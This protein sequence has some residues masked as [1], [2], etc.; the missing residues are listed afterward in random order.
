MN[1]NELAERLRQRKEEISAANDW[2]RNKGLRA[3]RTG[4]NPS[5]RI[6]QSHI[7]I[8]S[9]ACRALAWNKGQK[10][11]LAYSPSQKVIRLFPADD[12]D[13]TSYTLGK[14]GMLCAR[15]ALREFGIKPPMGFDTAGRRLR[16]AVLIGGDLFIEVSDLV[17]T[18][19]TP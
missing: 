11:A 16:D 13:G 15:T 9:S 3:T 12:G 10:V 17:E 1:A 8:N 4:G 6:T 14:N 19:P 18:S 7:L 2:V 5:V